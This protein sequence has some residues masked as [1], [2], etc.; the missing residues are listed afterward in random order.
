MP[1]TSGG[2]WVLNFLHAPAAA[3]KDETYAVIVTETLDRPKHGL[4]VVTKSQVAGIHDDELVRQTVL[5]A[6]GT[7][8]RFSR[9]ARPPPGPRPMA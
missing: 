1:V 5:L 6:E 7:A 2:Y 4:R 3:D 9:R 8:I